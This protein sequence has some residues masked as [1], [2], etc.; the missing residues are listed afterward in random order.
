M[1]CTRTR[2]YGL[3]GRSRRRLGFALLFRRRLLVARPGC[4]SRYANGHCKLL[5]GAGRGVSNRPTP[6]PSE[7]TSHAQGSRVSHGVSIGDAF[8]SVPRICFG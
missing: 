8:L 4:A 2:A 7:Q 3:H 6:V 1:P 5:V